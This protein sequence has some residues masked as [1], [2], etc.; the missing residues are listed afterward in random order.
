MT[1]HLLTA[2]QFRPQWLLVATDSF[3]DAIP[4]NRTRKCANVSRI[5]LPLTFNFEI[6]FRHGRS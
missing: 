2:E 6:S 3:A 4:R 5:V 1:L